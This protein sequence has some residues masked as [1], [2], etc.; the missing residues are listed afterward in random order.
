MK[1]PSLHYNDYLHL[2]LLLKAQ[3]RKSEEYKRPAHDEMLFI[4]VHQ[5]YE[6]WFKQ[7]L[8]EID[9]ILPLAKQDSISESEIFWATER[10]QRVV[11]IQKLINGQIDILE[12]MTPLDFLEFRDMLYPASGFQSFQWRL[13]ETK[14]GL[15]MQN[16]LVFNETPFYKALAPEQQSQIHQTLS[17]STLFELVEKWLERT[18]FLVDDNFV[19]WKEYQ[20]SARKMIEQD[21][22]TIQSLGHLT[23]EVKEK[24]IQQMN[25]NIQVLGSLF[26]E[27]QFEN[28]RQQKYF[29]LSQ[30]AIHAAL[31]IQIY[32]D[33]LLLQKPFEL[34]STLIEIDERLTEWRAKHGMMAYRMLGKKIGTGGS[35]GHDYLKKTADEHKV[36]TDFFNL[37]TFFIP[38]SA[39][40]Q[41]PENIL[42]RLRRNT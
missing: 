39:R 11:A 41:L 16:R 28:L 21:I 30:K 27:N 35:S 14:L 8:F 29:S 31:F 34:I 20:K 40:P 32:R 12:T 25:Q 19:F 23:A 10:L 42:K 24:S 5:A 4:I 22:E 9:S 38:R 3:S 13:I 6:L 37:S 7:I 17:E 36:F 33:E 1:Y 26:D 15:K 2:E 18:P